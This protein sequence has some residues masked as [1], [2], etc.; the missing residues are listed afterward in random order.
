MANR[1]AT[2]LRRLSI[3]RTAI[4]LGVVVLA[5]L[6]FTPFLGPLRI[7]FRGVLILGVFAL[8]LSYVWPW[9]RRAW[10]W[11]RRLAPKR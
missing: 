7:L 3:A 2:P 1:R 9:V 6:A 5:V 11:L 8:A 4:L 10:P